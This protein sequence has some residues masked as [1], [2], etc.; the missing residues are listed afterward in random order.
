MSNLEQ[1]IPIFVGSTYLDLKE[2]R[3][4]VRETLTRMETFVHGMEQFGARPDCPVEECLAEVRKC[5]IYVGIFAMRYGTIPPGYDKS[6]THLEYEEAQRIGLPSYIFLIDE[7]N[8]PIVP[9]AIDFENQEKLK[10][11]KKSLIEKHTPDYFVSP[12]DLANKVG[13]AIHR[14]LKAKKA[15]PVEIDEGIEEVLPSK[16]EHSAKSILK[17]FEFFPERWTGVEFKGSF[18]N[19]ISKQKLIIPER[20]AWPNNVFHSNEIIRVQW[21]LLDS[22]KRNVIFYLYA[23]KDEAY[24]MIE[25]DHPA[26]FEV[27]AETFIE[28]VGNREDVNPISGIRV[29]KILNISGVTFEDDIPF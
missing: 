17:R 8:G 14:A 29:K 12:D 18:G 22:G 19:Y 5:K 3:E 20:Y 21:P 23:E 11:L 26:V 2:H 25:T 28:N 9:A 6:L 7:Q 16:N 27:L 1:H 15:G 10:A 13:S 4:K 24:S